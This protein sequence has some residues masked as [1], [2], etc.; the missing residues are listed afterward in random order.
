[1]DSKIKIKL[2][3]YEIPLFFPITSC[4]SYV[5]EGLVLILQDKTGLYGIGEVA[6]LKNLSKETISDCVKQIKAI[7]EVITEQNLR[8]IYSKCYPSV[9]FGLELATLSLEAQKKGKSLPELLSQKTLSGKKIRINAL[10]T[11]Q[12]MYELEKLLESGY[13]SFKLKVDSEEDWKLVKHIRDISGWET[14]IRL[15]AN[16]IFSLNE[17][18][19]FGKKVHPLRVAYVEDPV[20][21]GFEEFFC[22]TRVAIGIDQGIECKEVRCGSYVKAWVIKPGIVG[23]IR[24][25]IALMKEASSLGIT[26]VL[27]NP[28]YSGIGTSAL[29][30]ISSVLDED[31]AMGFDPYRWIK[32][33]ILE[34]PLK[35]EKGSF[36]LD[37]VLSKMFKIKIKR[38]DPIF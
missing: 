4:N 6:P 7:S 35:V 25:S 33:D 37:D 18:I 29:V 1:M 34:A 31:I 20:S 2:Y 24:E 11:K 13:S 16:K 22:K 12:N 32:E 15:D 23:G 36:L 19:R 5:R 26:P 21:E 30:C 3:H 8:Y 10:L 17:G 9:R 14:E 27:S 28:F 38:L